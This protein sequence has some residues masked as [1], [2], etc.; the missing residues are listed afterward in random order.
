MRTDRSMT[1]EEFTPTILALTG[2]FIHHS[3]FKLPDEGPPLDQLLQRG[4]FASQGAEEHQEAARGLQVLAHE[5]E[6][7]RIGFEVGNADRILLRQ[8]INGGDIV[9]I[10]QG[11]GLLA[12]ELDGGRVFPFLMLDFVRSQRARGKSSYERA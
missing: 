6:L 3:I 11:R 12:K 7:R 2:K 10:D 1:G 8:E 5:V 9:G 4:K